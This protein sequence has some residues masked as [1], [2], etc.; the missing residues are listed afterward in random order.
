[1]RQTS[2]DAYAAIKDKLSARRW[3]ALCCVIET[4]GMSASYYES[5]HNRRHINKRFSELERMGV[6]EARGE[7]GGAVLWWPTGAMPRKLDKRKTWKQKAE[8]LQAELD[9]TKDALMLARANELLARSELVASR[10]ADEMKAGP[11]GPW[12]L[13]LPTN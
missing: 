8:A 9:A 3:E 4:P 7:S 5:K 6:I 13:R 12:S 10:I 11:S 1:M 2:I